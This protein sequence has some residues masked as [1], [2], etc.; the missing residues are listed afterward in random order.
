MFFPG[1]TDLFLCSLFLFYIP[2]SAGLQVDIEP[3]Q[4]IANSKRIDSLQIF[5]RGLLQL[6]DHDNLVKLLKCAVY[7]LEPIY[8]KL[9]C[10]RLEVRHLQKIIDNMVLSAAEKEI[11]LSADCLSS[12]PILASLDRTLASFLPINPLLSESLDLN[13]LKPALFFTLLRRSLVERSPLDSLKVFAYFIENLESEDVLHAHGHL[14]LSKET[15]CVQCQNMKILMSLSGLINMFQLTPE[16]PK[17][18]LLDCLHRLLSLVAIQ[19]YLMDCQDVALQSNIKTICSSL[20]G[21]FEA[22]Q[23]PQDSDSRRILAL[24]ITVLS[25]QRIEISKYL[26]VSKHAR[27]PLQPDWIVEN[28]DLFEGKITEFFQFLSQEVLP[29]RTRKNLQIIEKVKPFF[30]NRF[31]YTSVL[32]APVSTI[33]L[34]EKLR[35]TR[36]HSLPDSGY[37]YIFKLPAESNPYT[38]L[39]KIWIFFKSNEFYHSNAFQ[40]FSFGQDRRLVFDLILKEFLN[41]RELYFYAKSGNIVPSPFCPASLL[42]SV[43]ALL[44]Q[45][46]LLRANPTF[47]IDEKYFKAALRGNQDELATIFSTFLP[48]IAS[49]YYNFLKIGGSVEIE[50]PNH[51]EHLYEA[52]M[53]PP[54]KVDNI[55]EILDLKQNFLKTAAGFAT[56]LR[57]VFS[58]QDFSIDEIYFVLFANK[59]SIN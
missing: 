9:V 14:L 15:F 1:L 19:R 28:L 16:S 38:S 5:M 4:M 22:M 40:F 53:M 36:A 17:A 35:R 26:K 31:D 8:V 29:F 3:L 39:T 30:T 7:D 55:I 6:G 44:H 46:A 11:L 42:N 13:K 10:S 37:Q 54:T 27:F 32:E 49:F 47:I 59:K 33:S 34:Q 23:M 24:I 51:L 12:G 41:V 21:H 20:L 50:S 57:E 25:S 2:S 43:A 45:N 52:K 58:E 48:E 18:E 56:T